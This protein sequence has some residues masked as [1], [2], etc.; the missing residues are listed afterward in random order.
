[1]SGLK[2]WSRCPFPIPARCGLRCWAEADIGRAMKKSLVFILILGLS[3]F[4]GWGCRQNREGVEIIQIDGVRHIRNPG[5]PLK[6]TVRLKVEKVLEI[7][8]YRFEE[9][10]LRSFSFV[11]DIDGEVILFDSNATEAQR[12]NH[13]GEYLGSLVRKGQGPGEFP[14]NCSLG[15]WFM[16]N[17]IWV[18]GNLKMAKYDKEGRYLGEKK[19][20]Y[21][22]RILVDETW[23]FVEKTRLYG[24]K[25]VQ[26]L[27]LVHLPSD[28]ERKAREIV[29]FEAENAGAIRGPGQRGFMEPWAT[30]RIVCTYDRENRRIFIALNTEYKIHVKNLKGETRFIMEKPHRNVKVSRKDKKELLSFHM[31]GGP[32]KW[33][34]NA[35]PDHLVAMKEL[36][37]L[38]GGYLAVY[39]VSGPGRFD[40]DVFDSRG[41]YVYVMKPPEGISLEYATFYDFGFSTTE[42]TEEGF[43]VYVEYRIKNL[44][45]IF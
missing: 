2:K 26:A 14:D 36:N 27:I 18:T 33:M 43:Q 29:F 39:R 24:E 22:P 11:R 28:R 21:Y 6:G 42:T 37:M 38:P 34:L 16:D 23:F 19:L 35:Y 8:P 1:M 9:I 3:V 4:S 31:R 30:P 17:Q 10:G 40:V 45:E 41:R 15:V 12:F 13:K 5:K 20:G 32:P 7:N 44:P 25:P